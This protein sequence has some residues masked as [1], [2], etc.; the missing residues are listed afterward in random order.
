M[1]ERR[2]RANPSEAAQITAALEAA[3]EKYPNDYRFPYER[4]KLSIKGIVSHHETF[5]ALNE[6]A[7]KAID[8]GKAQEML[9]NLMADKDG[10]FYKPSRGHHEWEA[11][12]Q[13]L[14]SKNKAALKTH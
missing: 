1:R 7:E 6:A 13:A 10:D 12:L 14:Q 9:D 8:N 3:E 2:I 4:A 5:E 11:L